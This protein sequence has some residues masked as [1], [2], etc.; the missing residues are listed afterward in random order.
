L[1]VGAES[2]EPD[3]I[4]TLNRFIRLFRIRFDGAARRL[5]PPRTVTHAFIFIRRPLQ[6]GRPANS[7]TVGRKILLVR[8]PEPREVIRQRGPIRRTGSIRDPR[9]R[10]KARRPRRNSRATDAA[11]S[12][13]G[14]ADPPDLH[15]A[16]EGMRVLR[17]DFEAMTYQ[18]SE[19]LSP[20]RV[21]DLC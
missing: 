17:R 18:P 1:P 7:R 20:Y 3:A 6:A 21:N 12:N 19:R 8:R 5:C 2:V 14:C 13:C 10:A 9:M 16:A 11:V 4:S 15:E